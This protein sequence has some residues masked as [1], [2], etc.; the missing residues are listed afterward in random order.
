MI[1][2]QVYVHVKP[3]FI[4]EFIQATIENASSSINETGIARF[5][6]LQHAD[7]PERFL[8]TEVYR[9]PDAPAAHKLTP[10]YLKW[11]DVVAEMMVEPRTSA[12]YLNIYPGQEGW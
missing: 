1:I 5:D 11:R 3:E 6:V 2:M 8:L 4:Q 9:T 10:H 12:K 7:N